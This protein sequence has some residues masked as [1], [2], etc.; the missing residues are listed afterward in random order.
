MPSDAST[1]LRVGAPEWAAINA[2]ERREAIARAR[3][4]SVEE[5]VEAGMDLSRT[6]HEILTAVRGAGDRAGSS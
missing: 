1:L 3:A 2:A 4:L 6:A 5:R